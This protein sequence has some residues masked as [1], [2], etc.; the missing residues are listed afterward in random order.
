MPRDYRLYMDDILESC[1]KIRQF[2]AGVSF[3]SQPSCTP[4]EDRK[5]EITLAHGKDFLRLCPDRESRHSIF[6]FSERPISLIAP[7]LFAR[8]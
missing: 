3:Q 4:L 5:P 7:D 1:Q 8:F 2:T 6:P